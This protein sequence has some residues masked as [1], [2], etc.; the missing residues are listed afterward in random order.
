MSRSVDL[1]CDLGESFGAYRMG[2]DAAILEHITSANIACGFHAGG[3]DV[4]QR[5]VQLA[6]QKNVALGAH[7]G[8][9]DL[10]G[11]GR[12]ALAVSP[13]EA[14]NLT[15][16]QIGALQAFAAAQGARLR[17]VKPH[18]ALY[19]M[20]A[21][22]PALARA[23]A[24]AVRAAGPELILFGQSGSALIRAARDAGL[25]AAEEVFADRGYQPDGALT[26]RDSPGA[27]I[28]DPQAAAARAVRMIED[29][30]V[31][32]GDGTRVAVRADTICVHGDSPGA[33]DFVLA[34]RE[35]FARRGIAVA[36][37]SAP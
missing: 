10:A 4:M 21:R 1:N 26:P 29:G 18:G 35:A 30:W 12:R 6:V 5:T 23:I 16:Y 11:F 13:A 7:P 14:Y 9:P 37:F 20:A 31:E 15:L 22:D 34:L 27:L 2:Q 36:R 3:P 8:L 32:A 33:L 17:H 19:N 25:A 24:E 28:A